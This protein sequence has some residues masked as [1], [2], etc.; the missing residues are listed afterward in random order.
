MGET[1]VERLRDARLRSGLSEAETAAAIGL[2]VAWYRD[3]ES[4]PTELY[5]NISLA[6]LQV[7]GSILHVHPITLLTGMEPV[8]V[9]QH[10]G[11]IDL[12]AR[13]NQHRVANGLSVDAFGEAVG[14]NLKDVLV[15]PDELWNFNI[16]GLQALCAA[17]DVDWHAAVPMQAG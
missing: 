10:W 7:L 6:H 2:T 15:D 17:V 14:W 16:D 9:E 3:L 1:A 4:E 12:V 5:I 11:F 13:L 8:P